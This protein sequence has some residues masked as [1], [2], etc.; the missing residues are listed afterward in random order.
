[1]ASGTEE[2]GLDRCPGEA[3]L[4]PDSDVPGGAGEAAM[5]GGSGRA[6]AEFGAWQP[7]AVVQAV[8]ITAV[9]TVRRSRRVIARADA[10]FCVMRPVKEARCCRYVSDF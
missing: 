10:G 5:V 3:G 4:D 8:P 1:M 7:R 6:D 2:A 9:A